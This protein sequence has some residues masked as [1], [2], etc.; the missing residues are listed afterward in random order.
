MLAAVAALLAACA[1]GPSGPASSGAPSAAAPAGSGAGN[2]DRPRRAGRRAAGR[3]ARGA[4]AG[5]L[6]DLAVGP[7]AAAPAGRLGAGRRPARLGAGRGA[8]VRLRRGAVGGRVG[9]ARRAQPAARPGLRRDDALRRRE[10]PVDAYTY[11][12]GAATGRGSWSRAARRE[13][14]GAGRAYAHAL[15]SVAVGPDGA[16]YF[17]VGSHRQR[18]RRG[19]RRATRSGPRSCGSRRAAARREAY[20]RGVR[21]GTGL[22]VAPDG[23]VWTAVNNRD[24]IAYPYDRPYDGD[25]SGSS[26]GQVIPAYVNDHPLEPLARLTPGR[27]L[28][29]PYC[30]PDPDVDPG[31]AGSAL[32]YT[33]ARSSATCRPTPTAG[34]STARRCRRSS[35]ASARTPRRWG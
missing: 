8:V 15:K 1:A 20:A 31:V 19:P 4:R 5:R 29:W 34:G 30:N 10:R 17:S 14:P 13:E 32:T 28:G 24:N 12:G 21:N 26:Q 33:T 22:A 9:A 7:R 3:A 16:L 18:L 11:A 6:D 23:A 25:G 35:R 2:A 27:D